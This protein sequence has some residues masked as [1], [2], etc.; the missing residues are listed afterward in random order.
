MNASQGQPL[1][2]TDDVEDAFVLPAGFRAFTRGDGDGNILAC[3]NS[4]QQLIAT[5]WANL[6]G[7][8][9]YTLFSLQ[10]PKGAFRLLQSKFRTRDFLFSYV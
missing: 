7:Q 5:D 3:S 9:H 8:S 4:F 10:M 2:Q 6:I 1:A